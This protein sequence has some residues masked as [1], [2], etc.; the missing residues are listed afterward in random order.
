[1]KKDDSIETVREII[2][3]SLLDSFITLPESFKN[4]RVEITVRT[5]VGDEPE[6][7]PTEKIEADETLSPAMKRLLGALKLP[8]DF[9][10]KEVLTEALME[11]YL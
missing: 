4:K 5:L 7:E 6:E 8:K 10:Y 3:S 1:M 2:D 9:D 11:K